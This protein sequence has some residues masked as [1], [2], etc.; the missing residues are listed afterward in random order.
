MRKNFLEATE[1]MWLHHKLENLYV[2]SVF[3]RNDESESDWTLVTDE[4]KNMNDNEDIDDVEALNLIT[5]QTI[6]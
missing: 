6:I 1:G 3:L 2:K 5:G 4:Y